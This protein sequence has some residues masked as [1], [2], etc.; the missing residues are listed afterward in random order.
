MRARGVAATALACVALA[1]L[2][3][4]AGGAARGR[5]SPAA[6]WPEFGFDPARTDAGPAVTG[7]TAANVG[8]LRRQQVRLPGT[9]DSSPIYLHAVTVRGRTHDAFFVT[10]TYGIT[11]AVDPA[12][13][14]I[15]V[16]Y[17]HLTLPTI[18][19]V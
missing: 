16:S 9:V 1:C 6:D 2:A 10:T 15:P 19:S 17:T 5:G 4:G 11:L 3:V 14:R 18:C 12:T 7:I 13:G 8:R